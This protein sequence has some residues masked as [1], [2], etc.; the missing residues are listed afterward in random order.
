MKIV[1]TSTPVIVLR[2]H[3]HGA[4][5]IFRSLGR[6]GVAVYAVEDGQWAPPL[7]SRYCRGV[8]HW[9]A[10]HA[11]QRDSVASLLRI[12]RNFDRRPILIPTDDATA[13]LVQESS[14]ELQAAYKL[15]TLPI[16]LA[17][18]LCSKK[19]LYFLCR[20]HQV[21]TPQAAFPQTRADLLQ[22]LDRA[23]FP[24]V[25]KRIDDRCLLERTRQGMRIA[26]NPSELLSCY[27]EM[28]DPAQPNV[29][30]QEYIPGN[31]D[32]VWMFNG[33]FN[34]KSECLVGFT[35]R[36]L[37]Q[38]PAYTGTTSLGICLKN[39]T[40][41][42]SVR[43]LLRA[44]DYTGMVD[45][46]C[47]YDERDGQYKLLDV[48]PRVGCTFRLFVDPGGMDV[49]RAYYL[50]LT[51]QPVYAQAACEGR[52]WL[53]ENHDLKALPQYLKDR[54]FTVL[55]WLRSLRGVE[56]TAWFY[57]RDLSPAWALWAGLSGFL[58]RCL[59]KGQKS[60]RSGC[61]RLTPM[62]VS[63]IAHPESEL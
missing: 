28:E 58:R 44:I 10:G 20:E 40:V 57:W 60:R 12:A 7:R 1:D 18:R 8:F 11:P 42:Q 50:D 2:P 37:R 63:P 19:E 23:A 16:G 32:S 61:D 36:K 30:L 41:A 59:L 14:E 56:E 15:P 51:G 17:R 4:L 53:V 13:V 9:D 5:G 54:Q 3:H 31:V 39:E 21:P 45:I 47:R 24:V 29:M 52:K 43:A 38:C 34:E 22:F 46:G 48:N 25:L 62:S 55:E 6:L 49:I 33:Y 26:R 27:D 35:G